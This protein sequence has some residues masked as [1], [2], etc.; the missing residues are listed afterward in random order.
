MHSQVSSSH[1]CQQNPYYDN[2]EWLFLPAAAGH[3]SEVWAVA[4]REVALQVAGAAAV[5]RWEQVCLEQDDPVGPA[6]AC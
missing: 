5:G 6:P 4:I 2:N 1:Q 3:Q